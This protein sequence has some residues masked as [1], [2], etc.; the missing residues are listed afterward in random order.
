MT[1]R[2]LAYSGSTH[3]IVPSVYSTTGSISCQNSSTSFEILNEARDMAHAMNSK[4]SAICC[5]GPVLNK[6]SNFV[7]CTMGSSLARSSTKTENN[8]SGIFLR[9]SHESI[10]FKLLRVRIRLRIVEEE[11]WLPR[12]TQSIKFVRKWSRATIPH[13]YDNYRPFWDQIPIIYVVFD[14]TMWEVFRN[15]S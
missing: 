6:I 14:E 12:W 11:P 1:L 5:P 3:Q 13:I 4:A 10:R 7:Y 15:N 2:K 8:I 9:R